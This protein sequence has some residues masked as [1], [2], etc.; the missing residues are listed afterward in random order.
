[1]VFFTVFMVLAVLDT[2]LQAGPQAATLTA[3]TSKHQAFPR[4]FMP[5]TLESECDK[6]MPG[7]G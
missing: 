3:A 2:A 1:M 6:S 5:S 4:I 7:P